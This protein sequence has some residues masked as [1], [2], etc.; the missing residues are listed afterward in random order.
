MKYLVMLCD[1]MADEPNE[2]LGNS[3]PM[4]KANKPCMD[5]LAAK[6][7]VGI[8]KTVAEGLKPGSDVAN[9]SVL[10]YEP[11]VYYSG[12]SPLEAASIGIDLKDT[13]VTLR[14]NLV[15]LSDEEDYEK[16]TILDYCADDI[17]S[18]EA[19]IL[20]EYIQEK[21][22]NDKFRFYPGVSYRH[23]L[24]WS[25][26]NPHPGVLTPPHD[27][28]GKVITDYIPK[29]E[30]VDELY[31]LMKKSYD[32]LKDHPVNKARIARG[33]RP[34]NSIWL[35]GEGTKPLL[36]NFSEKFG[37]KGS[38]ISAVDLLKGI[39]ICA[40][41]NSVDVEGATGYLDT[42]FDGKCK[43]A[44]E[45]FKKG[46]DLVYIHVEAPDECGHRGEIENKVKAIEMI[47]EHILAPVV[48][49][50]RGYDDFAVLVCPDHPTPLSIRT[51]TSTPVPYLIYDSKNE[52]DSGV[53]VFCEKEARETGNYIEKGF[54]M[55]NY[56][57]TK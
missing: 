4:E 11:A 32:L 19:K 14:C 42:N 26:G 25:N 6:A 43:A 53:K 46:A 22:G 12:R 13:D 7:E 17:S 15:T 27:I 54:T 56:F 8:V 31:D 23:C 50:L 49:F 30:A 52:I 18:E 45:E 1:G 44:I 37:K 21:L 47:D 41:M 39:A 5:S 57:L 29:G 48:E 38:M 33:K 24:V 3:T 2:A 36:D 9:L 40:G 55:M 10:G 35:W 34:A 20:I 28:T 51:H 16:K